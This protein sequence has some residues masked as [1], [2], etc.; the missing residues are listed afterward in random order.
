MR[1]R[2]GSRNGSGSDEQRLRAVHVGCS[3]WD[4]RDWRG[5]LYPPGVPSA[6]WLECYARRLHTV[7]VNATFYR[8]VSRDTVARWLEQTPAD[9]L[10]AVKASRFLTHVK[11]LR[12][13]GEGV[14][15]FYESIE[16]LCEA[17]RLGAVLWQ[18]PENFTRDDRRLADFLVRLPVGRHALEFRHASWFTDA[19]MAMLREHNVALVLADHPQ[20]RFG[21]QQATADWRYVRFHYGARG[22]RGNYSTAELE[23]WARRL[24]DWRTTHEL[25]VYFNNDWEAFAPRNALWLEQRLARLARQDG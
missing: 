24:H 18:L 21:S 6:R 15:R 23:T 3:G 11:R 2:A 20:R 16:L 19:V 13:P 25:F 5:V 7:E 4:Y 14:A 10:F 1:N 9:F 12:D 17:R 22:R 8:L